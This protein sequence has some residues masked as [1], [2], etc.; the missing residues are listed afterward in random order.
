[1]VQ[2][3][4]PSSH[5]WKKVISLAQQREEGHTGKKDCEVIFT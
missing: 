5:G 4:K 2:E 1:M 3:I